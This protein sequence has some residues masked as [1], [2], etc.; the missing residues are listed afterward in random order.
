M[1]GSVTITIR[2]SVARESR[3]VAALPSI[4]K[5]LRSTKELE[6]EERR[7]LHPRQAFVGLHILQYQ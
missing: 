6:S 3:S 1:S 4:R 7:H 5:T 2:E